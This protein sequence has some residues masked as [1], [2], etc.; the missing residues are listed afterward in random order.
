MYAKPSCANQHS[1]NFAGFAVH[2]NTT[3]KVLST[4]TTQ[5]QLLARYLTAKKCEYSLSN[6]T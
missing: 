3:E 6:L 5:N 2:Q 4:Q 1:K